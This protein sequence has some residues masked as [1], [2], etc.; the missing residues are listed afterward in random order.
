MACARI[1]SF[2]RTFLKMSTPARTHFLSGDARSSRTTCRIAR[3]QTSAVPPGR[4]LAHDP[5]HQSSSTGLDAIP[6]RFDVQIPGMRSSATSQAHH[7]LPEVQTIS[8]HSSNVGRARRSGLGEPSGIK[9]SS[10]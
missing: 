5:S 1:S 8:P 6:A 10:K 7:Q 9:P 4:M 2:R 3:W